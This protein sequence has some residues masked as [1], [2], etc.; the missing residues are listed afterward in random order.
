MSID[1]EKL[2]MILLVALNRNDAKKGFLEPLPN[3]KELGQGLMVMVVYNAQT[4]NLGMHG[5][6]I[7]IYNLGFVHIKVCWKDKVLWK[8]GVGFRLCKLTRDSLF[9]PFQL[10]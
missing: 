3:R 9:D 1:L 2:V 7:R 8:Q 5:A 10:S 6:N 4:L